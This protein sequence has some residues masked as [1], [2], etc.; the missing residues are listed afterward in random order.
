MRTNLEILL[1][2]WGR[3][4]D[5]RR[6]KALGYPTSSAF[7]KE[8]V[9]YDGYG[10]SGPEACTADG[11]MARIDDAI[12]HLHP[13]MRVVIT[14]Q[15]TWSGPVKKKADRL[16][17]SNRDYYYHLDAAHK[18]LATVMGGSFATGYEPKLCAHIAALCA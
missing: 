2:D 6:D 3:R 5:I 17:I 9:N 8:R 4:Q 18:H 16:R 1:S 13:D 15:Y 11:D 14:A 10:Y 7:T 12:N